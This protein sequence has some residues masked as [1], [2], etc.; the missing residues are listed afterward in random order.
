MVEPGVVDSLPYGA[1]RRTPEKKS[2]KLWQTKQ[3]CTAEVGVDSVWRME[4]VLDL[5]VGPYD[6]R[7]PV[8]SFD[9]KPYPLRAHEN[10]PLPAQPGLTLRR[11]T[12]T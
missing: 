7:R 10:R 12:G 3:R 2:L 8:A 4:D 1:V 9:E 5:Y 6:P 11:T